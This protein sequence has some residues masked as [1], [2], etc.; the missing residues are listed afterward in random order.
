M[1]ARVRFRKFLNFLKTPVVSWAGLSA[2]SER[3]KEEG[4]MRATNTKVIPFTAAIILTTSLAL[5]Q[6]PSKSGS[7][8]TTEAPSSTKLEEARQRFQRG[9]QLFEEKN[10]EAARVEL[11]RAYQ[12]APTWKLL[13]NIGICYGQRGD[14]VEAVKDLERYLQEGGTQIPE[15][16]REEVKKELANLKPR[17]ARVT[18]KTNVPD[19]DLSIDDQP[20]GRVTSQPVIVNPGKRKIS[21]SKS[22][23]FAGVQVIEPAGSDKLDVVI[24]LKPLPK[25]TKTDLAPI[26]AWSVTGALAVGAGVVG[27]L[28]TR[29]QKNLTD[30]KNSVQQ[31]RSQLDDAAS[32]LKTGALVTDIL[33]AGT[34]VGAGVSVYLTWFRSP[35]D[36]EPSATIGISPG[37]MTFRGA[38]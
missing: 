36:K 33:L 13:Y 14:Y 9:L 24:D 34:I 10:F 16:R 20:A 35:S 4:A 7:G 25:P 19:A 23:Y 18:V 17:I 21:V 8:E 6:S 26:I 30:E 28:T 2:G 29:A 11:E 3:E 5:G 31:T 32:Q 27:Y 38:F 1:E 37:G 22:G 15:E 12:L